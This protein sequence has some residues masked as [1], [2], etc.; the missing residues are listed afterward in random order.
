MF[1]FAVISVAVN[2]EFRFSE[3]VKESGTELVEVCCAI[4]NASHC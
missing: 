2:A 4:P 1:N 3:N